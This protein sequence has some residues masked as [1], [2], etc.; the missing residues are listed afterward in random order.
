MRK[1]SFFLIATLL[2]I[3][4]LFFGTVM[5]GTAFTLLYSGEEHG[6]LGLHGCGSEQVGGLAHRHTLISDLRTDF[7]AV[8]N[9]HTGNL[10]DATDENAEWVY[11]IGLSALDA[12]DVDVLCLGPQELSFSSETLAALHAN[13]PKIAFTCANLKREIESPYL[14]QAVSSMDVAVVGLISETYAQELHKVELTQPHIAL[15]ELKAELVSKSDFVVVVFHATQDEAQTLAEAMPWIDVLIVA[16]DEQPATLSCERLPCSKETAIVTNAT[17]GAAVGM[18]TVKI[19]KKRQAQAGVNRYHNVSEKITPN[20]N[21]SHLLEAYVTLTTSESFDTAGHQESDNAIHIAYFHK[22]GCQKCARAVKVLKRLKEKYPQIVVD[23]RN[24]KTE[25][26]LFEAMGTLYDVPEIKRL[27]TPA[28]FVGDTAL[29]GELNEQGLENAIQKH[30][31]TGVTSR[32][33]E[34]ETH[35]G[36]AESEIVNR[37]Y[38]FGILTVAGAGLLDGINPCAFATIVFFI[39]YM[40]LVGRGRKEMLIAGGAFALAV[41]GTYLLLGLG[42]LSFM[43]YLNQYS[44]IAKCVYLLAATATFALAGLSLYDAVK[45]K[46]GKTKD[47]LLQLP[48][49]LKQRIHKVIREQTRTSGVIAGAMVIGF[50][51]SALE[52]VCTGQVYLPTLTFVAGIEGMRAHA[53]SYL[54]L[55]NIMFI[56]PLLVVFGCVYWGTTSMQL[57]GILQKHLVS[58]KVGIGLLLFGLGIWLVLIVV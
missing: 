10:I 11:Q 52:L 49:A 39:S 43:S 34:A 6:Q 45:A 37:F 22:H 16:N 24:A 25:Q 33:K 26:T 57:G 30:L 51:I 47:I 20:A 50:I 21:I 42:M 53:I 36:T 40:N 1:W 27:T 48:R 17:Q 35:K 8:L 3:I 14:I 19:N 31:K 55:Y 9:L 44:G 41:F 38:G 28:V 15:A 32:L 54:L 29:I 58:V 5:S 56:V 2:F 13:H 46:Q 4:L 18:L 23:Q 7:D 12:M